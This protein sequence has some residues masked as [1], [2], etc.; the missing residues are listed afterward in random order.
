MGPDRE[1]R[2][3]TRTQHSIEAFRKGDACVTVRDASGRPRADV[4]VS[5]EQESHDFVF[6]CVVPDL[7][8]LSD[9]ERQRYRAR[10]DELFNRVVPAEPLPS[11]EPG[12][13]RVE[14]AERVHLGALRHRLDELAAPGMPLHVHVWGAAVGLTEADERAAGRRVA[15]LYTLCFAHRAVAAVF[16]NGFA[17]GERGGGLL[18]RDLAP[19]YAHKVLQKLIGF[20][21]HSRAAGR[22]DA[23]GQFRFRGFYGG[24]RIVTDVGGSSAAVEPLLLNRPLTT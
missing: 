22:T 9:A 18:R 8:T 20:D 6:G 7:D 17:D 13:V 15:E 16:W 2:R 24:Y 4:A 3:L 23:G 10:L 5:V 14:V 12:V 21:W 1:A 19:K 11:A